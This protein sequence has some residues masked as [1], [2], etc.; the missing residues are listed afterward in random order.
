M[1]Y[2]TFWRS[3]SSRVW[4]HTSRS[5][6]SDTDPPHQTPVDM[7]RRCDTPHSVATNKARHVTDMKVYV[8]N[9]TDV[10]MTAGVSSSNCYSTN[11]NELYA[12]LPDC[13][14]DASKRSFRMQV[15]LVE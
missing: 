14:A 1:K 9:K 7:V 6:C 8:Q 2:T 13:T 10:P 11:T 12:L 5:V 15:D 4:H 3:E